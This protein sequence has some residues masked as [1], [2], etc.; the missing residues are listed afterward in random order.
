MCRRQGKDLD[1]DERIRGPTPGGKQDRDVQQMIDQLQRIKPDDLKWGDM[2]AHGEFGEV[3]SGKYRDGPVAIKRLLECKD[4]SPEQQQQR[5]YQ[6]A[7]EIA[8]HKRLGNHPCIPRLYGLCEMHGNEQCVVM[9][10]IPAGSMQ[11]EILGGKR[12]DVSLKDKL[13]MA[14]LAAAG[15][16]Q[17]HREGVVHRDIATRNF[18]L[19][20]KNH[21]YLCDFGLALQ[22][23][24]GNEVGTAPPGPMPVKWMAPESMQLN[25]GHYSRM[26]DVWMFGIF[27]WELLAE[28]EPY[29]GLEPLEVAR[30]VKLGSLRPEPLPRLL[31]PLA[32]LMDSCWHMDPLK[33]LSMEKIQDKISWCL[34][35]LLPSLPADPEP[36]TRYSPASSDPPVPD[37]NSH[38]S[39]YYLVYQIPV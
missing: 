22:L 28:Q 2:V 38:K 9:D 27:L 7:Q 25:G 4:A 8:I 10:F 33:R 17:A 19:G 24:P 36:L 3:W 6:F 23:A 15:V 39:S 29:H 18:L 1:R 35:D 30:L 31:K 13:E 26:T 20:A 34:E 14:K 21:V 5:R 37:D 11:S 32:D 16:M 12:K